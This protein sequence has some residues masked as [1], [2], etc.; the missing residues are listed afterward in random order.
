MFFL[1][2]LALSSLLFSV[3]TAFAQSTKATAS[4]SHPTY[5]SLKK[6]TWTGGINISASNNDKIASGSLTPQIGYTFVDR[7]VVGLQFSAAHRFSKQGSGWINFKRGSIREYALTPEVYTRYYV[8]PYRI[9]PFVQLST[10]YNFGEV[11]I[12]AFNTNDYIERKS[13]NNFVVSG[14]AG[15]SMRVGKKMGLQVQYNLPLV[16]DS[17]VNDL[18]QIN[19]FRLG[20][21]FYLK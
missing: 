10:G 6:G 1:R 11:S 8:L 20:M 9:T 15:V 17:K 16:V 2:L 13:T 14:A 5:H 12:Y 19:R 21:S 18:L 3:S 7:L 4:S